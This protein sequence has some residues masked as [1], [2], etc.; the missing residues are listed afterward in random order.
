MRSKPLTNTK[1]IFQL[2]LFGLAMGFA[3]VYIIPSNV[4]PIFWIAIFVFCAIVIARQ[5][6]NRYFLHGFLVSMLNSVWITTI[7]IILF[8]DYVVNHS[9]ELQMMEKF[10]LPYSMR[11]SMLMI[12]PV[13]GAISGIV[14]GLLC[15]IA[16]KII[17]NKNH[18]SS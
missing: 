9:N 12:G 8:E 3:T 10:P 7:H 17:K 16:S 14:L 6:H 11:I 5:C 15:V 18:S 2:S 4:E 13:I 1:L